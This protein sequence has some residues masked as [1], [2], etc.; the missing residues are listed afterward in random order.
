MKA[1]LRSSLVAAG[2]GALLALALVICG[3]FATSNDSGF[4][5]LANFFVL[6][7]PPWEIFWAGIGE[8]HNLRLWTFLSAA[9][10]VANAALY[11]PVGLMHAATAHFRASAR[12]VSIASAALGSLVLGHL[13][14]TFYAG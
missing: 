2:L 10:V 7:C 3:F 1:F 11:V 8:P 13:Y 12:F 9:V 4:Q 5:L 6:L 14:F